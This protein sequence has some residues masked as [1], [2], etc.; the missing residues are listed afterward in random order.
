MTAGGLRA[1]VLAAADAVEAARDE[2]GRL[3][4]VA[5]D[6]DH[7]VTMTLAAR[8]VR[9]RLDEAPDVDGADLLAAIAPAVASVGGSIGPV[10]ATALLRLSAAARALPAGVAPTVAQARSAAE[11]SRPGSS[12]SAVPGRAT[13]P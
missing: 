10:Y 4:A 11:S 2:L 6:G 3:D 9:A 8:A 7:G 13:R 12:A 5:G 1:C